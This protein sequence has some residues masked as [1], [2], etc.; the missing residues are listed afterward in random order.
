[1][2]VYPNGFLGKQ[3][4]SLEKEHLI[5]I[6]G[7]LWATNEMRSQTFSNEKNINIMLNNNVQEWVLSID[8][9]GNKTACQIKLD[10]DGH[11]KVCFNDFFSTGAEVY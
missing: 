1:M 10:E 7:C 4:T 3:L 8:V 6:A 11:F 2:Q 5:S 9:G